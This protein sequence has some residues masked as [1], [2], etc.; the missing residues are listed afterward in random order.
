MLL[1]TRNTRLV[2]DDVNTFRRFQAGQPFPNQISSCLPGALRK[3]DMAEPARK[4]E[5]EALVV[6]PS[7]Y[8]TLYTVDVQPSVNA[9]YNGK[10]QIDLDA[11]RNFTG[12]TWYPG[13]SYPNG[14]VTPQSSSWDGTTLT[15]K[16][17]NAQ[18]YTGG[19]VTVA[20]PPSNTVTISG[21]FSPH[22]PAQVP[23]TWTATQT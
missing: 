3:K 18:N 11:N 20:P 12:V 21:S 8:P 6:W 22:N 23:G 2:T 16:I 15:W 13:S 7:N 5:E 14:G 9:S 1:P 10:V 17:S 19:T 4:F